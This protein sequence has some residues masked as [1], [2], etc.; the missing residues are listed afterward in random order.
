MTDWVNDKYSMTTYCIYKHTCVVTNKSYIG[1]TCDFNRRVKEHLSPTSGCTAF[2]RSIKKHGWDNF[3]TEILACGL[4]V[5]EANDV[6]AK[7]IVEYNT[8]SPNGYNLTAGGNNGK[9]SE[10]TKRRISVANRG[11]CKTE[12]HKQK[13]RKP[14]PPRSDAQRQRAREK[15]LGKHHTDQAK[16][17]VAT[18]RRGVGK[19][20]DTKRKMS[21]PKQQV[22]CPHCKKEGG[23][24]QMKRWHFLNCPQK[25]PTD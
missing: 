17:K 3:T 23:L 18:A 19:S 22:T 7:M 2:S 1:Q 24:P 21:K 14:K 8:L 16:L 6:E 15:Q 13:L 11:K 5:N 20:D 4:S 25:M 12:E 9:L 10:E